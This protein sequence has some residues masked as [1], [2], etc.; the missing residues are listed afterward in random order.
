M[1]IVNVTPDSFADGGVRLD[2]ARAIAD[3]L[4]MEQDGADILDIGGES[5][6]P[7]ADPLP[8]EDEWRRVGPVL[9]GLR[10]RTRL[11]ISIDTYKA[12]I[13]RRALD[14]GAAIVNDIS[15]L[16]YDPQL[17]TVA[18]ERRAGLVLMHHRGRSADMY[19]YATYDNVARDVTAELEARANLAL[20][21]GVTSDR[22]VLDPG[23]GF[24]KRAEHT[25]SALVGLPVL[26]SL[27]FPILAGPSRKSFLTAAIGPVPAAGRDM[28]TAAA[29]AMSIWFGAHIV[30]VHDVAGMAHVA[31]VADAVR[32][33]ADGTQ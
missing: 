18:A 2:P 30:R 21:A 10:G 27:G 29:V 19:A 12:E 3:A 9:E 4:Q 32:A 16:A 11:P 22:I 24:A 8:V 33:A 15:G 23:F 28:A 7:G 1:A 25:F 5:T 14:A 6:R 20:A 31:R 26:A 17:A 13:A